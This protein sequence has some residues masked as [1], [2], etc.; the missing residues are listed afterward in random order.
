[1]IETGEMMKRTLLLYSLLI[2]A[3]PCFAFLGN[4]EFTTFSTIHFTRFSHVIFE[5]INLILL[6][7]IFSSC[8]YYFR[9]TNDERFL[10]LGYGILLGFLFNTVHVL[11]AKSFPFDNLSVINMKKNPS[12]IYLFLSNLIIPLSINFA[13]IYKPFSIS[14]AKI[15]IRYFY[16]YLFIILALTPIAIYYIL[17]QYTNSF[18]IAIHSSDYV[19]YALYFMIAAILINIKTNKL[20]FSP[21][22][23]IIGLLFLGFSG[24]AY[25]NPYLTQISGI[26][27][28]LFQNLGLLFVLI[29][30]V[31]FQK[32][33]KLYTLKDELVSYFSL[34]IILFYITL[35]PIVSAIF[36]IVLPK[37]SGY[38]FIELLL[39]FQLIVYIIFN[40]LWKRVVGVYLSAESNGAIVRI[41]ESI[42][43]ISEP[44][45]VKNTIVSEIDRIYH[46]DKCI[47]VIY[48]SETNSFYMDEYTKF[49]PSKTLLNSEDV[50]HDAN[51]FNNF[52]SIFKNIDISFS[53]LNEYLQRISGYGSDQ[54]QWLKNHRIKSLYSI[55]IKDS[56]KL[57]GYI[58][59][60]FIKESYAL[61]KEDYSF[62]QKI[63]SFLS[64]IIKN[65]KFKSV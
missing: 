43:R 16:L 51:D 17:P 48:N 40:L 9:Q 28:H 37:N 60:Y 1:M 38:I 58:I 36:N 14:N 54:E 55:P 33:S 44:N 21:D 59:L 65:S 10:I 19:S 8:Q 29:G 3:I 50:E 22:A 35:V 24:I 20:G 30:L 32:L 64:D 13:L 31:H 11:T 4:I 34:L 18:F 15:H 7:A 47:I 52:Q 5:S 26:F 46:P 41:M 49:L 62:L 2:I 42:N 61:S 63:A 25:I 56:E 39:L 45:I 6:L 53:T 27:G 57:L 23:F 12:L